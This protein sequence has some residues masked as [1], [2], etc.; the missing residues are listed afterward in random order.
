[1]NTNTDVLQ[2]GAE[3]FGLVSM[4]LKTEIMKVQAAAG[5]LQAD[6][7]ANSSTAAQQAFV[8]F[9]DAAAAQKTALDEIADNIRESGIGYT[10]TDDDQ[11]SVINSS[12][13][14]IDVT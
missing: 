14:T 10:G 5:Q 6:W 13:T 7:V 1:M 2:Q 8:R 3:Q 9:Q 4:G 12:M 11:M